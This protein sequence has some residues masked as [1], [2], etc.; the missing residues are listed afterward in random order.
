MLAEGRPAVDL[1]QQLGEV[2]LGQ[3]RLDQLAQP[4]ERA[5]VRALCGD[6]RA[7]DEPRA[8]QEAAT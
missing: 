1:D 7:G 8:D 3:P 6:R 2:D 5:A 4:L